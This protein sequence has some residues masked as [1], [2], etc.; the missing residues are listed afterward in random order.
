MVAVTQAANET[1]LAAFARPK[2]VYPSA[3]ACLQLRPVVE[4]MAYLAAHQTTDFIESV[5][6]FAVPWSICRLEKDRFALRFPFAWKRHRRL[7]DLSFIVQRALRL[8]CSLLIT[9]SLIRATVAWFLSRTTL[10]AVLTGP[11]W[12]E[13][14]RY[15]RWV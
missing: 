11:K 14:D 4:F 7:S 13:H 15:F 1:I 8:T 12:Q 2:H 10:T 3:G 5:R 6:L 9:L